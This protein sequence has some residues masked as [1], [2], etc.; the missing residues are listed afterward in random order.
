MT[1]LKIESSGKCTFINSQGEKKALDLIKKEDLLFLLDKATE[2]GQPF[3]MDDP[4]LNE[5][6]NEAHK[7]IYENLYDKFQDL[8]KN[9]NKFIDESEALYKDA[10]QKYKS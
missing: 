4:T 7:I 5:I 3:E 10:L 2:E 9:K 1:Y 8:L 6:K